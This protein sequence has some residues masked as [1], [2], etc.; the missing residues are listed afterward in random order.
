MS[1]TGD[2]SDWAQGTLVPLG[3]KVPYLNDFL[4]KPKQDEKDKAFKDAAAS[5]FAAQGES[6]QRHKQ[7]TDQQLSYF[8]PVQQLLDS[9]YG[10]K[11]PS[12]LNEFF[13]PG[14]GAAPYHG[15]PGVVGNPAD[16]PQLQ[17]IVPPGP[18]T[19]TKAKGW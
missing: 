9:M 12:R 11:D 6:D 3:Q 16:Y 2:V 7:L 15:T 14:P 8:K 4:P 19:P 13:N 10:M 17:G 5:F 18:T 1:W